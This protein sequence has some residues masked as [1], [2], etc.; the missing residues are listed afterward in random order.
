MIVLC[1]ASAISQ[2]GRSCDCMYTVVA[3]NKSNYVQV[4]ELNPSAK[5]HHHLAGLLCDTY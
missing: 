2:W 4:V 3:N 5:G 1:T